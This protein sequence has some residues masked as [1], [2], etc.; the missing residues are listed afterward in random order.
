MEF[1]RPVIITEY[2]IQSANDCPERDPFVWD[3]IGI[4]KSVHR[5]ESEEVILHKVNGFT[6]GITPGYFSR[7][8]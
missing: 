2:R 7:T 1:D 6:Q 4:R 8:H 3:L 5:G